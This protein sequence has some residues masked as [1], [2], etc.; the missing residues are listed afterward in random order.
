VVRT[1]TQAIAVAISL[2]LG[3][4]AHTHTAH[5][6]QGS[7]R[8]AGVYFRV[9][10]TVSGF[11]LTS[12]TFRLDGRRMMGSTPPSFSG[13]QLMLG[14]EWMPGISTG[15]HVDAPWFYVRVG[16]DMFESPVPGVSDFRV[17]SSTMGWIS[18]GPR[19][20]FGAFALQCGLRA[21]AV[22]LDVT[23]RDDDMHSAQRYTGL[24]AIYAVDVSAQWR[25]VR[26]F[27][28]DAAAGQDVF[29]PMTATTFSLG[30][31]FGWS[32]A[33]SP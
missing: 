29:G 5:A 7:A 20:I 28:L 18:A 13:K 33:P 26:W 27:Q 9:A 17:E 8:G 11:D 3:V 2:V 16:V 21:G 12:M 15:F 4:L 1:Q 32:R 19:F 14:R 22:L 30:A 23:R 6:Q 10:P 24:G 31:S 25:P